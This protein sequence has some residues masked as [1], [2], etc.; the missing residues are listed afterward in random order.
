MAKKLPQIITKEDYEKIIKYVKDSKNKNKKKYLLAIILSAEA[1]LRI[2]EIVGFKRKD[3]TEVPALTKDKINLQSNQIRIESA[4]GKKDRIVPCP[5]PINANA[6]KLLPF[7]YSDRRNLQRFVT[8]IG[9]KAL[10][11][12]ITF[13]SLRHFFG[14]Q[15]AERMPLHEI[16]MLMGHSRLDT[17]GI[18]LH[19]NPSKA[20]EHARSIFD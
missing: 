18:Y 7:K 14:S 13:H 9:H 1:G 12:H 16:Q 6:V 5:K 10:D 20:I 17:T 15:C 8:M 3:K 4:K 11:K 2:S 19:A